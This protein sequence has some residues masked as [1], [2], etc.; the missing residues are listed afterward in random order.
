MAENKDFSTQKV[1][2]QYDG[3]DPVSKAIAASCLQLMSAFF[4]NI[5]QVQLSIA[6]MQKDEQEKSVWQYNL[7][8]EH[9]YKYSAYSI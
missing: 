6:K 8:K 5:Q 1:V 3:L 7:K 9:E 2:E 4:I